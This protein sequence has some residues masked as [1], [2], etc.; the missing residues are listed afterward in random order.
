MTERREQRSS[1]T[2]LARPNKVLNEIRNAGNMKRRRYVGQ[3]IIRFR[4]LLLVLD[5]SASNAHSI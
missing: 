1:P 5:R 2:Q 3:S 4:S